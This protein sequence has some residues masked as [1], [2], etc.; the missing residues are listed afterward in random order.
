MVAGAGNPARV[1]IG[2]ATCCRFI[3]SVVSVVLVGGRTL[4]HS[5]S[6][7]VW[8]LPYRT[9]V[10]CLQRDVTKVTGR[11]VVCFFLLPPNLG[12]HEMF[13]CRTRIS[14]TLIGSS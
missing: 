9:T 11:R 3:T 8:Y 6:Y 10:L 13:G 12:G 7:S 4:S 2:D 1:P 14:E 5:V